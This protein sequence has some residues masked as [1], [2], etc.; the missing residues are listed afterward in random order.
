MCLIHDLGEAITGDIPA[1][2]KSNKDEEIEKEAVNKIIEI[3][4]VE[5]G[6]EFKNIFEEI[7][8][9]KTKESKLFKAL[10][11]IEVV[12]QHN[13]A[14]IETWIDLEYQLNL[15]YGEKEAME[16]PFLRDLRKELKSIS[17]EKILKNKDKK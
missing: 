9:E 7:H 13:E 3:L 5:M 17:E 8:E 15:V 4:D 16:I 14:P 11:K 12:I 1:F 6:E 2:N 10:D